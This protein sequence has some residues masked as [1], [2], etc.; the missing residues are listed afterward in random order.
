VTVDRLESPSGGAY[1]VSVNTA[2]DE[3]IVEFPSTGADQHAIPRDQV[4]KR[5]YPCS[6]HTNEV[7]QA[8][9]EA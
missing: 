5:G 8:G 9:W 1:V 2:T 3:I 6:F 4:S 7:F